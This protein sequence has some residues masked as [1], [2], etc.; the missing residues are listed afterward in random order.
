MKILFGRKAGNW[1]P[2]DMF[3]EGNADPNC[4]D[5]KW[6]W[7]NWV[8]QTYPPETECNTGSMFYLGKYRENS[9]P[10]P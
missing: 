1:D 8:D 7:N 3:T 10:P 9:D 2:A 6:D 5:C 4:K